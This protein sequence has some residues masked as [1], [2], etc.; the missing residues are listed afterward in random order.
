MGNDVKW[1]SWENGKEWGE[2]EC[3]M[4]D[5]KPIMTYYAENRPCYYTYSA[6]FV[7]DGEVCYYRFDQDEG[8]WDEELFILGDY[9]ENVKCMF[10]E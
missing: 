5:N 9:R 7:L 8:W 3:P 2:I 10:G 6:P 4:L 1:L